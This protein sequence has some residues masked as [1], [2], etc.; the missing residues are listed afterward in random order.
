MVPMYR[1]MLICSV[2]MEKAGVAVNIRPAALQYNA[3]CDTCG[4]R[5]VTCYVCNDEHM[6]RIIQNDG[7]NS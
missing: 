6:Q 5:H 4:H 3:V 1:S 2:C 7:D